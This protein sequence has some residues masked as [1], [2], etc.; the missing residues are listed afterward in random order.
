MKILFLQ[1][2]NN[3]SGSELL[4]AQMMPL[5]KEQGVEVE[6]LVIHHTTAAKDKHQWFIDN[7]RKDGIVVYGLY[8]HH[9]ASPAL[10]WKIHKILQKGKYDLAHCNLPHADF[11]MAIQ[12]LF[13]WH[14]L[15]LVSVKH[16][17]DELLLAKHPGELHKLSNSFFAWAQ[18]LTGIFV[19]KNVAISRFIYDLYI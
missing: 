8:G 6:M 4:L 14:K 17:F 7:L 9:P 12:K 13:F 11:W 1:N 10:Q 2:I 18:R 15:K 5:L 19:R 16:G 3:I